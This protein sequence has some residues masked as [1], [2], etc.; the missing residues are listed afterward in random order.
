MPFSVWEEIQR[1]TIS[2]V[3]DFYVLHRFK[4]YLLTDH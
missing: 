2:Q 3:E 4:K 1:G